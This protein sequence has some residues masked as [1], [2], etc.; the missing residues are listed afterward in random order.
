MLDHVFTDAIGALRDAFETARLERQAFE[1]HFQSDVLLG[2]LTWQTSYGLP[3]EGLPPRVQADISCAWPTWS[4]TAYRSW[5]V[6]EELSE[7]PRIEIEI[8]FR[9]QQL[10]TFPDPAVVIGALP[11]DSPRIGIEALTRSGPTV[12]SIYGSD[13]TDAEY[14]I[15]VSYEGGYELDEDGLA[16]GSIL[17]QHFGSLGGWIAA[18][19][20]TVGDLPYT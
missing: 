18:T 13:L 12:E 1:E 17:D 15:E 5:Y 7:A 20:V 11:L 14:A 16:D 9:R 4:Q 6:E 10:T 3:G 8:V 2:D 19:L